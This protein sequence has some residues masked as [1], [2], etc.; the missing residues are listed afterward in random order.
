MI[1]RWVAAVF[2]VLAVPFVTLL[3]MTLT[4]KK[5]AN[6]GRPTA[7]LS[8]CPSANNC[9]C[10]QDD[11]ASHI[12]P[13]PLGQNAERAWITVREM[14]RKGERMRLV[15]DAANYLHIEHRSA[16]F[17][18]VDDLEFV[19]DDAAGVIHVRAAARSGKYDFGANRQMVDRIR[20]SLA[21]SL[22]TP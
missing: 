22:Q 18:F 19:R 10:S 15:V 14:L 13:L 17:G 9:V 3:A 20:E 1:R 4:A 8:P 16:V 5:P 21:K 7:T 2:L 12:D 6:V 11:G